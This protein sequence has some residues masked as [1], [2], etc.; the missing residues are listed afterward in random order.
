MAVLVVEVIAM[1]AHQERESL[2]KV[3]VAEMVWVVEEKIGRV[4]AV[5]VPL[6]LVAL[7]CLES[8]ATVATV[9]VLR[10]LAF[11]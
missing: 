3:L 6:R 11:P 8:V 4:V 5:V 2:G 1:L 7:H 10:Y 9:K